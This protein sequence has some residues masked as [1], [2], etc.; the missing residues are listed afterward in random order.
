M[1]LLQKFREVLFVCREKTNPKEV[2]VLTGFIKLLFQFYRPD[3]S[4]AQKLQTC[5]GRGNRAG[6][7]NGDYCFNNPVKSTLSKGSFPKAA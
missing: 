2:I 5:A 4:G 6:A 3:F 7:A 1:V